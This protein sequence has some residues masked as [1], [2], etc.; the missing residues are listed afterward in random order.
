MHSQR[1]KPVERLILSM[2]TAHA[3]TPVQ[4]VLTPP[5]KGEV[6][7]RQPKAPSPMLAMRAWLRRLGC[8]SLVVMLFWPPAGPPLELIPEEPQE[9]EHRLLRGVWQLVKVEQYWNGEHYCDLKP[10]WCQWWIR[11]DEITGRSQDHVD[12]SLILTSHSCFRIDTGHVPHTIDVQCYELQSR[13]GPFGGGEIETVRP[14]DVPV[15]LGIYHVDGDRLMVAF[16]GVDGEANRPT[17]FCGLP[18][19]YVH[20]QHFIRLSNAQLPSAFWMDQ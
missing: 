12:R 20:V 1:D 13:P 2:Q 3:V 19:G 9:R 6:T 18:G 5:L 16:G 14:L 4:A 10:H 17:G 15:D 7:L 8:L 11:Q